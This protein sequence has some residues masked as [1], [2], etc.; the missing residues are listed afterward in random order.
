VAETQLAT[1]PY[2]FLTVC[3][4]LA[5]AG[6]T[7]ANLLDREV[8]VHGA[9][10]GLGLIAIPLL[11]QLGAHVTALAGERG[12]AA[13]GAAGA[14]VV[15]DRH[16]HPLASLPQRFAATFNFAHWDDDA[17]LVARLAPGAAGHATTVHPMLAQAD[18]Y[19]VAGGMLAALYRKRRS[20]AAAPHGARYAWTVFRPDRNALN[21]LAEFAA[22]MPSMRSMPALQ[23]Y[24][25]DDAAAA[26]RHVEQ[27]RPGRVLLLPSQF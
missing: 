1:L 26:H 25:L 8:L 6:A 27:R 4:A 21:W 15:L 2:N 23:C 17:Q 14:D 12:L 16:R 10:G 20:A 18:R 7:R 5:G 3:R 24:Q 19:G 11:K 22:A 13:C 9:S